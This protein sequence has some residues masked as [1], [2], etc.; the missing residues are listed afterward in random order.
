MAERT[1]APRVNTHRRKVR[2]ILSVL[3]RPAQCTVSLQTTDSRSPAS[4]LSAA[5]LR[6]RQRRRRRHSRHNSQRRP[7]S[8]P[9]S[10]LPILLVA[11]VP[12][13]L[14]SHHQGPVLCAC[15]RT[16]ACALI[17]PE[18]LHHVPKLADQMLRAPTPLLASDPWWQE[19]GAVVG[20]APPRSTP[21]GLAPVPPRCQHLPNSPAPRRRPAHSSVVR[22]RQLRVAALLLH[23]PNH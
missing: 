15:H 1:N 21:R 22:R 5:C 9:V 13:A 17:P 10:T 14:P 8:R 23:P 12:M 6:N 19:Q 16:L 2:P 18:E 11:Q 7:A 3:R 4:C 20:C